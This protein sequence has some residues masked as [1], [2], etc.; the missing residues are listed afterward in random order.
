MVIAI[1]IF[2]FVIVGIIG[3]FPLGLKARSESA[4]ETRSSLMARQIFDSIKTSGGLSAVS[5]NIGLARK[6]ATEGAFANVN[7]LPPNQVTIGY[8]QDGITPNYL[9]QNGLSDWEGTNLGDASQNITTKLRIKSS[10]I[11]GDLYRVDIIVGYPARLPA[12][13]RQVVK[14]SQLVNSPPPPPAAP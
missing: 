13:K 14:F 5:I 2:T 4:L 8:S 7:L 11:S 9:F 10:L 3:I 6:D 12:D 1:G